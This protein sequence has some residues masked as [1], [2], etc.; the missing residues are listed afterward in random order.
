MAL[1]K[2]TTDLIFGSNDLFSVFFFLDS[3]KQL[4][5]LIISLLRNP[6][7]P[8]LDFIGIANH[9]VNISGPKYVLGPNPRFGVNSSAMYFGGRD[10]NMCFG[11]CVEE[12][13]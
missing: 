1:A 9:V 5:E 2:V 11:K 4:P 10:G 6:F 8:W 3:L 12:P 7:L 13:R